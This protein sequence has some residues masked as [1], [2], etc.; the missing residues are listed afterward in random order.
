M[1]QATL[2]YIHDPLCGWCYATQP[3]ISAAM[4]RLGGRLALQLHGG[5]LFAEPRVLD[6]T[7]AGHI[8]Q[9]DQ[10]IA[11][12]SGQPF[13]KPYLEGLLAE[14]GTV[15]YSMPPI[16]AVLAALDIDPTQAYPLLVTIQNAHYQR[17]LRVVEPPVLG[18]LAEE[19]GLDGARFALAFAQ[20]SGH[21]LMEHVQAS[22]RLLESVGGNGF[23]TLLLEQQGEQRLFDH[24]RYYGQPQA[25]VEALTAALPALH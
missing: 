16:A 2:H 14:H 11:Q 18:E 9:S 25:F 23:P 22:R 6:K 10:R 20:T 12:Y 21:A 4:Q 13:G 19:I 5:G 3:L 15:F 24:S 7:L 8:A 17:G 1:T